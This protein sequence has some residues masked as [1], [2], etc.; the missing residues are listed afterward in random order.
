MVAANSM[1]H[2]VGG[3]ISAPRVTYAADPQYTEPAKKSA[4]Q[5]TCVLWLIVGKDG[6]AHD[7]EIQKALGM[8]LDEQAIKAV[9]TWIFDPALKDG[10]AVPVQIN[11]DV[12]FRLRWEDRRGSYGFRVFV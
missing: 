7:I 4:Y 3:K 9:Q 1:T 2:R 5:G 10:A 6:H 8:G 12:N 11:V